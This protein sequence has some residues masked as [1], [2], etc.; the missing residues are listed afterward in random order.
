MAVREW[1]SINGA[2]MPAEQATVS[3]FDSSFM[4]GVG[5]FTTMRAY[6]GRVFRLDRHL[7]RLRESARALGWAIEPDDAAMR[8]AVAQVVGAT[9]QAATRVR[10]TLST[11]S[12]RAAQDAA[13]GL[14]I[15][16]NASPGAAYPRELYQKGV[17]LAVSSYRQSGLDP[18]VGHKTTSY[19]ARLASLREAHAKGAFETVWLT[20]EAN[21]A[22]AA[23]ANIFAVRGGTLYTPPLTTPVLPGVTRAAVIELAAKRRIPV[24]EEPLTLE[25]LTR[26]D[27]VFLTGSMIEILPVVRILREPI[28]A[29]KIGDVTRTLYEAMGERIEAECGNG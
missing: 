6:N 9:E 12:L 19:F 8:E 28:G 13:A 15:V 5:L 26:A 16:A 14:T 18:T 25:Q 20:L 22:E 29:E 3:V 2:I 17:T 7:A 27:E 24:A 4:Q 11:G 21:V 23:M 10:L 1:V